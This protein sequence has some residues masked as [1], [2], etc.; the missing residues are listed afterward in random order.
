MSKF[1]R[2]IS[3]IK[4]NKILV[5]ILLVA[6]LLRFGG[7]NP[8][9]SPYHSDEPA[10]Y[11][12]ALEMVKN[13]TLD[14][15]RYDYPATA[16]LIN[17][18]FYKFFFIPLNW[19]WFYLTHIVDLIDGIIK[20]PP[21]PREIDRVFNLHIIGER[22]INA[23]FWGRYITALFGLGSVFLVYVLG[24]N[25][26]K[27][28]IGLI[29]AFF[30][31]FNF[32]H[33]LNSHITLPDIYNSFFLLLSL[34]TTLAF[35]KS[36]TK[37]NYLLAGLAVGL[38]FSI[39]YQ[40]HA[41]LPFILVH[42]YIAFKD[43]KFS[44]KRFLNLYAIASVL[45]IPIVFAITNPYYLIHFNQALASNL[46]DY[47][48]YGIG[49][50]TLNLFPISYIYHIDFGPPLFFATLIGIILSFREFRKFLF[51]LSALSYFFFIFTYY[52]RGGFYIRNI[53]PANPILLLF[54]AYAVWRV[55]E[56]FRLKLTSRLVPILLVP[57]LTL[58]IF[59]PGRNSVINSYYSLKEWNYDATAKWL[60][61]NLPPEV[62]VAATPFDVP[63]GPKVQKTEFELNGNYSLA[64]H[65]E[66]GAGYAL[67]NL[68][69]AA[70]NF[71]FW[72]SIDLENL[73]YWN[74]PINIMRNTYHGLAAEELFRYQVY[75]ATKPWQAPDADLILAKIPQWPETKTKTI[76]TYN[77]DRDGDGWRVYTKITDGSADFQFD[78]DE[79]FAENGS[80]VFLPG[81]T[82]SRSVRI[83]SPPIDIKEG[84][85]YKIIGN[86][87]TQ[88]LLKPREREGFLR[89]DFFDQQISIEGIGKISSVSS[90]I[91]GTN[92][93][94]RKEMIERAPVGSHYMV[95]SFQTD[96][97]IRTKMW[98]DDV[99][100]QQSEERIDDI[101]AKE[102]Y[103]Y[104][105][106]DLNNLY[107]F[108]HGNL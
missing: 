38:S 83:S 102:P 28:E 19:V 6:A 67:M 78:Q 62:I 26:F 63:K 59:I 82:K 54:A 33:V 56:W 92:S 32:R 84:Y 50:N 77:F 71:Y 39:K 46:D 97:P 87:K 21:V 53:I 95:I 52:S 94:V 41:F 57:L 93:W 36:P 12:S 107:P 42:L 5:L 18:F 1:R 31:A 37:K 75:S 51:L 30:L 20:L 7:T 47:R 103:Q 61:Q 44:I 81:S 66:A 8:G 69:W 11:G 80:L 45:M 48:K 49:T 96:N 100:V 43:G 70:G 15:G 86:L 55:I 4:N 104:R 105:Q 29:A 106:I 73:S 58:L 98:L 2:F 79:G 89:I 9:Y 76:K 35:W 24:K 17:A 10:I 13:S 74:Q 72:M 23:M 88:A 16:M 40:A 85:L 90:R 60:R 3:L 25:L 108:S 101:T 91:Y 99:G 68:D 64:E 14:P 27:K 65:K 34:I 22:G